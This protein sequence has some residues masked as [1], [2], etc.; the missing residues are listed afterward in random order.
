M[1]P[2]RSTM[3]FNNLNPDFSKT[4]IHSHGRAFVPPHSDF[5]N[6]MSRREDIFAAALSHAFMEITKEPNHYTGRWTEPVSIEPDIFARLYCNQTQFYDRID[7]GLFKDN[8]TIWFDRL[9]SDEYYLFSQLGLHK[10]TDYS[11]IDR[12]PYDYRRLIRN[13][14]ELEQVAQD[15]DQGLTCDYEWGEP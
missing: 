1:S 5:V 4:V 3:I 15:V 2:R 8:I 7:Q 13:M 14:Q 11:L 6:I 9:V 10:K 12:S